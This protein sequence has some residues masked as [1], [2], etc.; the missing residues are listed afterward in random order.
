MRSLPFDTTAEGIAFLIS[1]QRGLETILFTTADHPITTAAGHTYTPAPGAIVTNLQFPSDATPANA[2]VIIKTSPNGPITS[3][4]AARGLLDYW[5]IVID[6]FDF[7]ASAVLV[8][9]LIPGA[10]I[11]SALENA[12]GEV[13][14]AANGP[15]TKATAMMTEHF[16]LEGRETLGDDRCK[17]PIL[18][19]DITRNKLYV[20]I[21]FNL[22]L[23]PANI[24]V[25][26]VED[27]YGRV[28][29][30]GVLYSPESYNNVYYECIVSGTT[31]PTTQ[32]TYGVNP[33]DT[34]DDGT[35][36]FL[37]RNAWTRHVRGQATS[38]HTI[39]FNY[40]P[41]P[42]ATDPDWYRLGAIYIRDGILGGY[43]KI[44]IRVW[45]PS[46]LTAATFLFQ[47][48]ADIPAN[49]GM[50]VHAGCN[51]TRDQC[52]TR[53]DVP[54]SPVRQIWNIRAEYFV[55]PPETKQALGL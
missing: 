33:G 17:V 7:K 34:T 40:L 15:L 45:D 28:S 13:T 53:F 51:W 48:I 42:R 2:D 31:D 35:A 12:R 23:A 44:P 41:D 24:G 38:P 37:T 8:Y 4:E 39:Q 26:K 47:S 49:T 22:G 18:P 27:V 29:Q 25:L 6:V 14:L 30:G 20:P 52:N 16:S 9:D 5:P 55:P 46:T 3:G 32:P 21:D 54:D 19:P 50:E 10:T 1:I 11:G 36:T 43:P